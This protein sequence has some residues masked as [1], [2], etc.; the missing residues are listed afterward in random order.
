MQQNFPQKPSDTENDERKKLCISTNCKYDCGGTQ[1]DI[2]QMKNHIYMNPNES[3]NLCTLH[4]YI[5]LFLLFTI[6]FF[7]F[8]MYLQST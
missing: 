7:L 6:I 2:N 8:T 4:G 3:I 1:L 5:F